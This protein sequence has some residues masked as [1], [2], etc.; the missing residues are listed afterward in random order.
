MKSHRIQVQAPSF[1]G[2]G[3][4]VTSAGRANVFLSSHVLQE[5]WEA[6]WEF[7]HNDK[8]VGCLHYSRYFHA[9]LHV[10][11]RSGTSCPKIDDVGPEWVAERM[12]ALGPSKQTALV[13]PFRKT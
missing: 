10:G 11:G 8:R 5:Q 13:A 12:Q 1:T 4:C 2:A 9:N 6:D 3:S 7:I